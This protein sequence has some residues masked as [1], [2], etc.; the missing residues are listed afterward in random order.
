MKAQN[1]KPRNISHTA[2][3]LCLLAVT[4]VA[5]NSRAAETLSGGNSAQIF[6]QGD[7]VHLEF[8]GQNKWDYEIKKLEVKGKPF[9]QI[10]T[11]A[12]N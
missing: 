11:S 5:F 3:Q 1:C 4:L 12:L 8:E 2:F 7:N 9:V 10:S 6:N